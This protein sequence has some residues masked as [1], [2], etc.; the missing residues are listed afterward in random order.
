MDLLPLPGALPP[1]PLVLRHPLPSR[2]AQHLLLLTLLSTTP[3]PHLLPL[4]LLL[5]SRVLVPVS[6]ARW[7]ALLR[8]FCS[9]HLGCL[10]SFQTTR[11]N[12]SMTVVSPSAL[13]LATQSAVSSVAVP[14]QPPSSS[15]L[16]LPPTLPTTAPTPRPITRLL[17]LARLMSQTSV[18]AWTRTRAV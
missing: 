10:R 7:L 8:K 18:A 3:L 17:E 9:T 2:L 12:M 13:P 6:S 1:L 5:L 15:K 14:L 11:A 4:L 16:R